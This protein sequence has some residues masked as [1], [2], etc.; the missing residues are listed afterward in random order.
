[1]APE[2]GAIDAAFGRSPHSPQT[3]SPTPP[4]DDGREGSA[5]Y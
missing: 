4:R 5:Y 1:M 3:P 2:A